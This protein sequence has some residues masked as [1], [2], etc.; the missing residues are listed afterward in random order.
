MVE[1]E[2]MEDEVEK[3]LQMEEMEVVVGSL[4]QMEE[5]EDVVG[6]LHQMVETEGTEE[7]EGIEIWCYQPLNLAIWYGNELYQTNLE[8][9]EPTN[10]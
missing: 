5:M 9:I 1:T 2:E 3:L 6:S 7:M 4:H 10:I 8:T